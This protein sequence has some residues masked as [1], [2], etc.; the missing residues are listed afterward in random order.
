MGGPIVRSGPTPEFS[1]NWD[2][3]FAGKKQAKTAKAAK[4]KAA[5]PKKAKAPKKKGAKKAK[6]G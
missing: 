1:R 2:Q 3:V 6:K 4:K 5:A